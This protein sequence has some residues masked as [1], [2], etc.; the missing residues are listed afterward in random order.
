MT[1]FID[2]ALTFVVVGLVLAIVIRRSASG[3]RRRLASSGRGTMTGWGES[4]GGAGG[5][6][7]GSSAGDGGC[8]DGGGGD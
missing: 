3:A 5:S 1:A 8:G 2:I 6:D 7:C 4:G